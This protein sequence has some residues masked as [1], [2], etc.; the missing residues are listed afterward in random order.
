[1][2][3]N[4]KYLDDTVLKNL[5]NQVSKYLEKILTDYLYKTSLEFKADINDFGRYSAKNFL[6]VNEFEQYNWKQNYENSIF[7]VDSDVV[8]KSGFLVTET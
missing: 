5:S 6:T 4:S 1:M 8:I 3:E 7:N 2:K